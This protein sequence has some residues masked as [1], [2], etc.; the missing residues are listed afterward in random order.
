MVGKEN[1]EWR[2][3]FGKAVSAVSCFMFGM[4]IGRMLNA[5]G[6]W[7]CAHLCFFFIYVIV[8]LYAYLSESA[9]LPVYR[10]VYCV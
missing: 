8:P 3:S 2:E 1:G 6:A 10:T 4:V 9:T 5:G 7:I